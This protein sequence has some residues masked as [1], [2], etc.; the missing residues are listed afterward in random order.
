MAHTFTLPDLGEGLVE[1]EISRWLVAE[2]DAV[3]ANDPIVEIQTDKATVEV[4]APVDGIVLRILA[5]E[6]H[7]AP[8]GAPLAVIGEVGEHLL[9]SVAQLPPQ[10]PEV[11]S[12]VMAVVGAE[13]PETLRLH[14]L[15]RELGVDYASVRGTGPGGSV[16]ERDIRA[17]AVPPEGRRVPVRGI[18]RA[19]VEQV[20]RTH[21][22]IPA[23]TFV[24][25]CDF[26]GAELGL[27]VAA[28]MKAAAASLR[29]YPELNARIEGDEIVLLDRY[30]LG[31]AVD[32][33][34]GLVVPVVRGVDSLAIDEI[35]A[36]IRRL[37]DGARRGAL[38]PDEV[39]DST[40]TITSAGRF[41]GLVVTPLINHPEVAILGL[42]RIGPRPVVRDGAI[43]VREMGN[44]SVTFDHRVVDGARAGAFCV[45]VIERL[46]R[47]AQPVH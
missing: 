28:A 43:V 42:H 38:Q 2:G 47:W 4:G 12:P 10:P 35:D 8:V 41:G 14:R 20:E 15:A 9:R 33:D 34:A 40:F 13:P 36:E 27:L 25:E 7:V 29:A 22:E 3:A 11:P 26:S 16:T 1:G 37:A 18:R 5:A 21:R 6:G 44:V 24:E 32:T 17:L 31:V 45:D 19:I 39:R 30:D 23:V 46:E